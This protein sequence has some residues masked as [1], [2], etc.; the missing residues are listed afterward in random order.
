MR[1]IS[2]YFYTLGRKITYP[3]DNGPRFGSDGETDRETEPNH[4]PHGPGGLLCAGIRVE[5]RYRVLPNGMGYAEILI[6]QI[7]DE[8]I[9]KYR[10]KFTHDGL[11]ACLK[12][13]ARRGWLG[14]EPRLYLLTSH[15][16]LHSTTHQRDPGGPGTVGAV[17]ERH[18]RWF[19]YHLVQSKHID[20]PGLE[21][22]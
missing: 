13:L 17:L 12:A 14:A 1:N 3:Y 10:E 8:M 2:G 18:L 15:L 4:R 5:N 22:T 16:Y 19:E 9:H 7:T 11:G 20:R 21:Y 6:R